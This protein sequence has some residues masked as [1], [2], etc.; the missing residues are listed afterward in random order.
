MLGSM[1]WRPQELEAEP[2]CALLELHDKDVPPLKTILLL[3]DPADLKAVRLTCKSLNEYIKKKVWANAGCKARLTEKLVTRWLQDEATSVE[4][5]RVKAPV[6]TN[7]VCNERFVFY[8]H[9]K[10]VVSVHR[11]S[12]DLVTVLY[13]SEPAGQQW[14]RSQDVHLVE[15]RQPG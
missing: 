15:Q 5:T 2:F 13:S 9:K 6:G 11:A 3:L 7:M 8:S 4:L 10:G 12:G 1:G 14:L